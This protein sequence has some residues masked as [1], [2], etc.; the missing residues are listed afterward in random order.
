M[1]K[2]RAGVIGLGMGQSHLRHF[3]ECPQAVVTAV[4]DLDEE[5]LSKAKEKYDIPFVFTDYKKMLKLRELD[6]VIIAT[7]NFLHAPMSLEALRRGKHVFCEKPMAVNARQAKRM[8]EEAG[9]HKKKLMIHFNQRYSPAARY[10]KKTIEKGSLGEIYYIKTGWLR[11]MGAPMTPSFTDKSVSGGGPLI[12]LGVH[13][14]DLVLW[15][16]DY[17][18][19]LTVSAGVFDK[20]AGDKLRSRGMKYDVED[21]GVAMLRLDTGAVLMLEASWATMIKCDDEMST[22]IFG[23]KGSF[24]Q[25]SIDYK[26]VGF[27]F[28]TET[29]DKITEVIPKVGEK[30]G[31]P[32]Q[33]FVD[34]II[35][36]LEPEVSGAHG[37]QIMKILDAIYKSSKLGREV[38]IT[39]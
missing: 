35:K 1:K 2:V 31:S 38:K 19:V 7:P 25:K 33:H 22:M 34:C 13:R 10:M 17:P 36:D 15:L 30:C 29:K 5:L 4:C 26:V 6:A 24:E 39:Y 21:L 16:L 9:K 12:D 27:N 14:L 23:T 20:I 32:Q 3:A 28:I 37:L 11:R 8:V 18:G